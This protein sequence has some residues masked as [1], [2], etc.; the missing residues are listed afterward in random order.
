MHC[1]TIAPK[2]VDH[3]GWFI[4]VDKFL[5]IANVCPASTPSA[6]VLLVSATPVAGLSQPWRFS[7]NYRQFCLDRTIFRYIQHTLKLDTANEPNFHD[8]SMK[9]FSKPHNCQT[10]LGCS[11]QRH[12]SS[13]FTTLWSIYIYSINHHSLWDQPF[14]DKP[15]DIKIHAHTHIYIYIY[16]ISWNINVHGLNPFF[17]SKPQFVA[18]I[19][20]FHRLVIVHLDGVKSQVSFFYPHGPDFILRYFMGKPQIFHQSHQIQ[21]C[22][23]Y[24]ILNHMLS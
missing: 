7:S 21:M 17:W 8:S 11:K 4:R 13:I 24:T 3:W 22:V 18:V 19:L 16:I 20:N 14:V 2:F 5:W 23:D 9:I 10:I 15:W 1:L 12:K 6:P